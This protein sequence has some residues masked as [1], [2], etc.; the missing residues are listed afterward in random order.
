MKFLCWPGGVTIVIL[1]R[2]NVWVETPHVAIQISRWQAAH[3]IRGLRKALAQRAAQT[4]P[5]CEHCGSVIEP[6]TA[7]YHAAAECVGGVERFANG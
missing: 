5:P 3:V 7:A 2:A 4:A 6:G 1:N